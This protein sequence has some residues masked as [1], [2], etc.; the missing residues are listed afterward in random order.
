MNHLNSWLSDIWVRSHR[1]VTIHFVSEG[2]TMTVNEYCWLISSTSQM[3]S[4]QL[5][6]FLFQ[7]FKSNSLYDNCF[8]NLNILRSPTL[9]SSR[10]C[11]DHLFISLASKQLLPTNLLFQGKCISLEETAFTTQSY[12][13]KWKVQDGFLK[14][15]GQIVIEQ[16]H[17]NGHFDHMYRH[18]PTNKAWQ[19]KRTLCSD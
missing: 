12:L 14:F 3:P 10:A 18:K 11:N 5:F 15:V 8:F 1:C 13:F 17:V 19:S 4:P 6:S 7:F 2:K 16:K 9:V